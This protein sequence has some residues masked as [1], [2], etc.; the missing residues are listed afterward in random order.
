MRP[1]Y[2]YRNRRAGF[3]GSFGRSSPRF[4]ALALPLGALELGA[5]NPRSGDR[6][7]AGL[8]GKR[9][10]K[11]GKG[12]PEA[13]APAPNPSPSTQTCT[14]GPGMTRLFF[15]HFV[16]PRPSWRIIRDPQQNSFAIPPR[17]CDCISFAGHEANASGR[18]PA[19]A[20]LGRSPWGSQLEFENRPAGLWPESLRI[21]S[22]AV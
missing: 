7:R 2:G 17:L 4:P 1:K 12:K 14:A 6:P 22:A 15:P 18:R 13:A 3:E 9:I 5:P 16:L 10:A 8:R 21:L 19:Y 11:S 20:I